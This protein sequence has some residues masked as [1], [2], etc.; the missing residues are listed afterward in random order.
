M[1][2]HISHRQRKVMIPFISS[3]YTYHVNINIPKK[4]IRKVEEGK[5]FLSLLILF[6]SILIL[7]NRLHM[8]IIGKL[9]FSSFFFLRLAIS[10][11]STSYKFYLIR[12]KGIY[13]FIS[14]YD[15][16]WENKLSIYF[17]RECY[18]FFF[19]SENVNEDGNI[20][21]WFLRGYVG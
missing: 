10:I 21:R 12:F 15:I 7:H 5:F 2:V 16:P 6:S 17:N 8:K 14:K 3:N 13:L 9:Y 1:F 18:S 20:T 4:I 11:H 19:V